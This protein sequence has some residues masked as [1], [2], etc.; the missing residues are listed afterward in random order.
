[1][2][3][4]DG[5]DQQLPLLCDSGR[6]ALLRHEIPRPSQG[7][8]N[9]DYQLE[10]HWDLMLEG[11]EKLVTLQIAFLPQLAAK[12]SLPSE[13]QAKRIADH[14]P[15][16]LEYEGQIS[17][18]RGYVR[19]YAAGEYR[20]EWESA[21]SRSAVSLLVGEGMET[22]AVAMGDPS[23]GVQATGRAAKPTTYFPAEFAFPAVSVG[24]EFTI[25]VKSWRTLGRISIP[26]VS[27]D[28]G[29]A[30]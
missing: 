5:L 6:F 15:L 26:A 9:L 1:M 24:S 30:G 12:S 4:G 18:N 19:R 21:A 27:P 11:L 16:Y 20:S 2:N 28:S 7:E 22:H 17:G 13:L 23:W 29:S 14:R 3:L 10:S 8:R 25:E